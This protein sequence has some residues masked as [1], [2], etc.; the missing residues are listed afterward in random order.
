MSK[1]R[2]AGFHIERVTSFVSLLLPALW[3][4]R[5]HD[6]RSGTGYDPGREHTSAPEFLAHL[7]DLERWAIKRGIDIPA[8]GSLI[9]VGSRS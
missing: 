9:L 1:V 3:L 6:R 8:G 5:L 2:R 7:L 4:S